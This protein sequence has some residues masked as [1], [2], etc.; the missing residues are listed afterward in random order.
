MGL[1][2]RILGT[3]LVVGAGA[4]AVA[5]VIAAPGILRAA[6]PAAREALRGGL[7]L[8]ERVREA[9]SAFAEDVEDIVVEVQCEMRSRPEAA[10]SE[11]KK[12]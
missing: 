9:A 3:V 10:P 6:R 4:L 2:A 8:Y 7:K 12:A 1:G 5:A 11:A